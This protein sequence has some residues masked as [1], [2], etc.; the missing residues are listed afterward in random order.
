MILKVTLSVKRKKERKK[1][2]SVD[3]L[4]GA[5]RAFTVR[6]DNGKVESLSVKVETMLYLL[7]HYSHVHFRCL[8]L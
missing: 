5:L 7:W 2:S 3:N 8:E 1:D 4:L 6:F